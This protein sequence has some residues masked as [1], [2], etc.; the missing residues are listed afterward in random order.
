[1]KHF[2]IWKGQKVGD[3]SADFETHFCYFI[4]SPP[5]L[6]YRTF[7]GKA[8]NLLPIMSVNLLGYGIVFK[9]NFK[10]IQ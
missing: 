7:A 3:L 4:F 8:T 5:L 6:V 2:E 1:M 9:I 10:L